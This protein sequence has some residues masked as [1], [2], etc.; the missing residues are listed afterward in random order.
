MNELAEVHKY[1]ALWN[2]GK[3]ALSFPT[4]THF[5]WLIF[6]VWLSHPTLK[7]TTSTKL[8]STPIKTIAFLFLHTAL[9]IFCFAVFFLNQFIFPSCGKPP[10]KKL[11]I[12]YYAM[13]LWHNME[14][15]NYHTI[16]VPLCHYIVKKLGLQH[17][18]DIYPIYSFN[19]SF[20][21]CI[22][23]SWLFLNIKNENFGQ[24]L[25]LKFLPQP[26]SEGGTKK[27]IFL[28]IGRRA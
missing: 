9:D 28:K 17:S 18:F 12:L 3:A 8:L 16:F 15:L 10:L 25:N 27:M 21:S 19:P 2:E 6:L 7:F 23:T 11:A 20:T 4:L 14:I 22:D 1:A 13:F 5:V 26:P 24:N